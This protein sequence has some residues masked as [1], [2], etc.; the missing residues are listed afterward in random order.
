MARVSI[1]DRWKPGLGL[2]LVPLLLTCG[3][4][5]PLSDRQATGDL[6]IQ[7]VWPAAKTGR[8]GYDSLV[9]TVSGGVMVPIRRAF[10]ISGRQ[11][12]WEVH[13]VPVGLRTVAL[14]VFGRQQGESRSLR[15]YQSAGEVTVLAEQTQPVTLELEPIGVQVGAGILHLSADTPAIGDTVRVEVRDASSSHTRPLFR[16]EWGDGR[17][18][19]WGTTETAW[20]VYQGVGNYT[21]RAGICDSIAPHQSVEQTAA[22]VVTGG[23]PNRAPVAD[24][25]GD[26]SVSVGVKV[27][28]DGSGS[29]DADGDSLHYLWSGPAG[30]VLSNG[31]VVRP[32]FVPSAAGTY[33]CTLVV[34]DGQVDSALDEVVITATAAPEPADG[35]LTVY[36]PGDATMEF[37]WIEP[38]AFTMG[39]P[40]SE[41]E[42][43][44]DE[45][46]THEVT[47]SRGYWLGKHEVTQAQWEAVM[48]SNPSSYNGANRPVQYITWSELQT[49]IG[50]LNSAAG[51]VL[52]RLPTEA[53]WEYACR[54]GTT[55]RWS[56]GDE[57]SA[58][59]NYAWH[60]D[61][62][63]PSGTKD[64][65]TKEPN[66][67][68]L[69]DMHGNVYEWCGDWFG[70]YPGSAQT[71]PTGPASGS[72]RVARGGA[73]D[74]AP[75]STRSA[76]RNPSAAS[77][78]HSTIGARLLRTP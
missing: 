74:S 7:V 22:V 35:V 17:V 21:L 2:L 33:R 67:W 42:R 51:A 28:L 24:A 32:T 72:Y 1:Y 8:A 23:Q 15:L 41:P 5:K 29:S 31:M 39:S 43:D 13:Q 14:S 47:I 75:R 50:E 66:P 65:G 40:A 3:G 63:G 20:H 4:R 49:F 55:T 6:A 53:E 70:G 11:V 37:V 78:R 76:N 58:L 73:F 27:Q 69:Y 68:G 19:S 62:N 34:S 64:V 10:V 54:A 59:T 45:G 25:G 57:E 18:T 30:V 26:L 77:D 9:V 38:G 36:L 52:Y 61:N 56:Y 46:P 44:T 60:R 16:W 12:A 71:D 48:G